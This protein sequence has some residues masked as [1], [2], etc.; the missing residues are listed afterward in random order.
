MWLRTVPLFQL[1]PPGRQWD[2]GSQ[3]RAKLPAL[4]PARWGSRQMPSAVSPRMPGCHNPHPQSSWAGAG[5]QFFLSLQ[6]S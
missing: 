3:Q 2:A 5:S 6:Q 1:S 4:P